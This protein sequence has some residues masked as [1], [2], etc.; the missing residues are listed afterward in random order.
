MGVFHSLAL[1]KPLALAMGC[2]TIRQSINRSLG[3]S[4]VAADGKITPVERRLCAINKPHPIGMGAMR[5]RTHNHADRATRKGNVA[6]AFDNFY[7]RHHLGANGDD[8]VGIELLQICVPSPI[9]QA[10]RAATAP[11]K[12]NGSSVAVVSEFVADQK[13]Q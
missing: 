10:W 13:S 3:I 7:R 5:R 2:L 11:R 8:E 9:Q 12:V 6:I 1:R 4:K